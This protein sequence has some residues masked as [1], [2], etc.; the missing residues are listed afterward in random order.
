MDATG[1]SQT[2]ATT[3]LIPNLHCPSCIA[4]VH[5]SINPLVPQPVALAHSITSH[6]ITVSHDVSLSVSAITGALEHAGFEVSGIYP[7]AS[8]QTCDPEANLEDTFGPDWTDAF[9]A[10]VQKWRGKSA[11]HDSQDVEKALR[12]LEQ[13]EQCRAEAAGAEKMLP[14]FMLAGPPQLDGASEKIQLIDEGNLPASGSQSKIELASLTSVAVDTS[15][16]E[17]IRVSVMIEGMTCSSCVGT[18]SRALDSYPWIHSV[19]VSLLT[20]SASVIVEGNARVQ[21]VADAITKLGYDATVETSEEVNP[22]QSVAD[23]RDTWEA[24]FA[25]SGMTCSACVANITSVLQQHPWV[26]RADV[27]LISHSA[28]VRFVGKEHRSTVEQTIEDAGHGVTLVSLVNCDVTTDPDPTRTLW[29]RVDGM[30]CQHCPPRVTE[31]LQRVWGDRVV[32]DKGATVADPVLHLSYRP[33]APD[34]T[35]RDII[36]SITA[37]DPAFRVVIVHPPTLEERAEK[38]QHRTRRLIL[39]RLG[40]CVLAAIPTFVIGI[41]LMSLLPP[42]HSLREYIMSP[43][44][45]GQVSRGD[46]ALFFIATPVYF[47][48]ADAFHRPALHDLRIMWRPG[49]STPLLHRF[50]RFG[51]MS[52]L[53][54]LGTTIAY[55]SSIAELGISATRSAALPGMATTSYFDSVVFLTMFLLIGRFLEA[56]SKAKAGDAVTLLGRL[57]PTEALLALPSRSTDPSKDTIRQVSVDLLDVGDIVRVPQGASPPFDAIVVE[58][59]TR[60]DEASLT[61]E[62]RPVEKRVGDGVFAGTVNQAGPISVRISTVAGS[63]MLDQIVDV[64]RQGQARR[65]PIERV[66]DV[67]TSHFVPAVV[68]FAITIWLLWLGL[69][70]SGR[71]PLGYLDGMVGGWPFWSLQFAIAVFVIACPCGIGLAAPTALFVG[72]GRAARHG[73]LVKGGG[74]AFQEA[75]HLDCVVFDKTGTLTVGSAPVITDHA[76]ISEGQDDFLLSAIKALEEHST[77]PLAKAML[78]FCDA[79]AVRGAMVDQVEEVAGKGMKGR[80]PT[81]VGSKSPTHL[82]LGNEALLADHA[83]EIDE[84]TAQLMEGW[85]AQ[86]KSV[87]LLAVGGESEGVESP[88][89]RLA[90]AFAAAD[91]LRPEAALVVQAVQ[92]RGME[93]W[94]ISG[95]HPTT[96]RA[97]GQMV[98]IPADHILAGVLPDQ[99]ADKIRYL[100]RSLSA[101]P[102][103]HFGLPRGTSTVS[104][105]AIVAMVG[106]GINDAPALAM[107]DV[108]IALGSGSDIA[109]SSASFVLVSS[110]LRAV[111]SL[112]ELSRA[113]FRRVKFNFLWALAYNLVALPIAAG[114][115]YPVVSHGSHVRLDPVW[116]SL[117][118]AL[119]SVSVV[120]SSLL[121]KTSLP[122]VG[123]RLDRGK[124]G[125]P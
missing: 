2:I 75:S 36:A 106:D 113:V 125:G 95:D 24:S 22:R 49:S 28:S 117:A 12:H 10:A 23:G 20:N 11:V 73:I 46:W 86:A 35:A 87:A 44:W 104:G 54:S 72:G 27:N 91:P 39:M 34:F 53:M 50:T 77:H 120:S 52:M 93:V 115:L 15:R 17:L 9:A 101:A 103:S 48:A 57:R 40:L 88:R 68:L 7:D 121:L 69:G 21:A 97:V 79:R 112:L 100:Q 37:T 58:G 111:L 76:F 1:T 31:T 82:L 13:C 123:V 14:R 26:A 118:M 29:M 32:V 30:H 3:F 92:E 47:F 8:P 70:L 60:F 38:M 89:W 122:V 5:S 62:S 43:L 55:F 61:G 78:A 6:S 16:P 64:V 80:Q 25:I 96:A 41:V 67:L 83:V 98:G 119:S 51:S 63:S 4:T 18:I 124:A 108:G 84:H 81:D 85:K 90:A 94:M 105:H 56:Y 107:A 74:E 110:D 33:H 116:A 42:S 19:D 99:K 45:T 71:L 59:E 66:A 114:V 102:R 109:V 65:A